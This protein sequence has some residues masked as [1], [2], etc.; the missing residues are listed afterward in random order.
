M[1]L[2]LLVAADGGFNPLDVNG[3][4]SFLWTLVIFFAAIVPM[5]KMVFGKITAALSERD[6]QAKAAIV[7]AERASEEAEKSRAAVEVALGE[8]QAEAAK[9]LA[10]ARERAETR[11]REIIENAKQESTA[12]IESARASIQAEQEK[13]LATIRTEV[14]D[15][16]LAAAGKVLG[17]T[18]S[19]DDDRRLAQEVI[20]ASEASQS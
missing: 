6:E 5:W 1:N 10:S 12:M 7:A 11:E 15:L 19:G 20:T 8:A 14:V 9:L 17:R 3:L 16:S 4:G 18:V 2:A 13:A